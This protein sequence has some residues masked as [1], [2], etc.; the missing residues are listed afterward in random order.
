LEPL[1][2]QIFE[3]QRGDYSESERGWRERVRILN[4]GCGNSI[5]PEEMY[6][7]GYKHIYN[8]DISPVV[9]EQMAKRNAFKRPELKC[10]NF[11]LTL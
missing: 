2:E 4:L 5:L 11:S 10:R 8:V 7:R 6:D 3:K 9:I 1:L